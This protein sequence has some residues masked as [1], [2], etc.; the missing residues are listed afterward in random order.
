MDI[1][2]KEKHGVDAIQLGAGEKSIRSISKPILG[3]FLKADVPPKRDVRDFHITPE[4]TLPVGFLI[5]PRHFAV[6]QYVDVQSES[7]G[8]GFQGAMK[9][10]NFSGQRATHGNTK[11]HRRLGSIGQRTY[12]GK[13]W[14]GKKMPGRM[15]GEI[16]TVQNLLVIRVDCER[17]LIYVKGAIPGTVGSCVYIK[18][19]IKKRTK[20]YKKLQYP[21]FLP[22]EGVEYPDVDTIRA[23]KLDPSD[24]Y[25][26]E[27]NMEGAQ[28]QNDEAEDVVID[29]TGTI[30][31]ENDFDL[32]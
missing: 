10:W 26:H 6:G 11:A 7:K 32:P 5:S 12:P 13:V 27:N 1:K 28:Y 8:K 4:N 29:E 23:S 20:Q 14:K 17:S 16:T 30:C 24:I 15:G 19:A 3:L 25:K 31:N 9:R 22:V 2:T 18:D 21:T